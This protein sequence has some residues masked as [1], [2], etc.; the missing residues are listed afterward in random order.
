MANP[1]ARDTIEPM[2]WTSENVA[3]DFN[4]SREDMDTLAALS[5][6]RAEA[7]QKCIWK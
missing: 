6:Q 1:I 2:G 4:I 3:K 5:F 7:A